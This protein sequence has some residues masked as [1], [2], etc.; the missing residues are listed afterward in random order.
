[1]TP[2]RWQEIKSVLAAALERSPAERSSFLDE[3]C[4]AD[5][6]LRD[7]VE[8]LLV[9]DRSE[10]GG[11]LSA[12]S[13]ETGLDEFDR[14]GE[15]A[16]RRIGPYQIVRELG[17]GGMGAVYLAA[18]AD[19]QYR[20]QTA[21]KLIRRGMDTDFLL[22]RFRNERQILAALDHP[23]IARLLDG[24]STED[25]RPYLVMEYVAGVPINE[26]CDRHSL[27]VEQRLRLFQDACAAVHYAHQRQVI[28]RDIK[29]SN[30]LVAEGGGLKLLDFGIAKLLTPDLAAQ[31]LDPTLSAMRLM[32]PAYASPEQIKGDT[33]TGATDVYSLGV[34]LYELLTGHKPYRVR[35][36]ASH[37]ITKAVLE[38]EPL[39]P[40]T[41]ITLTEEVQSG[42][43]STPVTLTPESV[44]KIREG[45]LDRLRRRL[46]GDLD[47]IVLMALR[48]DPARRYASVEQFS[49]DI[50]RHLD[51][52]PIVARKDTLG[53]RTAKFVRRNRVAV[54]VFVLTVVLFGSAALLSNY[55]ISRTSKP[56]A[57]GPK[58]RSVAV[59]PFKSVGAQSGE[60]YLG[61]GLA[62]EITSTLT[63]IDQ[64]TVRPMRSSLN[65]T[66][67]SQ[68]AVKA[69]EALR[70]DAVLEGSVGRV[71]NSLRITARLINVKDG[72]LLWETESLDG[73]ENPLLAQQAIALKVAEALDLELNDRE[74]SLLAK[75]HTESVEASY[76]YLK[77]RYLCNQ[78][79]PKAFNEG[80]ESFARAVRADPN[81]APAHSGLAFSQLRTNVQPYLEKM[82]RA[83]QS[84][85]RALEIDDTL[86]EAHTALGRALTFCDW[87]WAG[88]ER[89]FKRA[90][91]L[92]P[93]YAEAHYWYSD[94]LSATGRHNEAIS[95]LRRAQEIDPFSARYH[96]RLGWA[97]YF[98][99]QYDQAIEHFRDTPL[100]VDD[101][102]FQVYW[103]LGLVY[104]QKGMYEESI[105]MIKK[106]E[107]LSGELPLTRASLA[108]AY[109]KSGN[110]GEAR[111]ILEEFSG[112]SK[113]G[114]F[115]NLAAAHA[116][117]GDKDS[118]FE[119]LERCYQQR[120]NRIIHINVEPM[121]ESLRDD[122]RFGELLRHVHLTP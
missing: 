113:Q 30:I 24:G 26:Y 70:V 121:L 6:S 27:D 88:A 4:G 71:G 51:G 25:G 41:T 78:R 55:W 50:R 35:N 5:S 120:D 43:G 103:R 116:R 75:P 90:I 87:D 104:L 81:F 23:N 101:S 42:D 118:A 117:L 102:N 1:V 47:N 19:D 54:A 45:S 72:S 73:F 97:Y 80:V 33:I 93:N 77:G 108:Y 112:V 2:E 7:E 74:G 86:A 114:P 64:L 3:A 53:Y 115:L 10:H 98:S 22:R 89:E 65:F 60:E 28:H 83:K 49:E 59:R 61:P 38:E 40:S 92:N 56:A 79:A 96:L 9:F 44:S 29:P 11:D 119:W 46:R 109:A 84:A 63:S 13:S 85:A 14:V 15:E 39:K 58:A 17:R 95:A 111:K 66:N 82:Q 94:N 100:D 107:T 57:G 52:R 8:A 68:D 31:T 20:R 36:Q 122:P 110:H 106:A 69:G 12:G 48:K 32:T 37:E 105:S 67:A 18:R 21:I 34:M 16:G 62:D 99:H 76:L 91:E